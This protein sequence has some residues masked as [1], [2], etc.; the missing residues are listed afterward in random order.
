MGITIN[1][2]ILALVFVSIVL[3]VEGVFYFLRGSDAREL[4]ANRRM[5]VA[6]KQDRSVLNPSLMREEVLGGIT[7]R[8]I[9][10]LMPAIE[11]LFWVANIAIKPIYAVVGS[12]L[13]AIAI[14]FAFQTFLSMPVL[15]ALG[16]G[17]ML[18]LG[19]PYLILKSMAD[20]QRKKFSE[21]LPNAINLISRGLQAG[22]PVPVTFELV[23]RELEDPIGGQFGKVI[24]EINFGRDRDV[25]LR[26]VGKKFP[27][28]DFK[29][30]L[31]AIEMQRE[32][33]GNLVEILDNLSKIIRERSNMRKKAWAISSEGRMTLM[34]VGSLPYLLLAYFL[35]TNPPF[36]LDAVDHELFWPLMG[37]AQ[38][39]WV[40]GVIWIWKMVNIKV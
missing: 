34:I 19:I 11:E 7:S 21:Q 6:S 23:A 2:I 24:D 9:F 3:A 40:V 35:M 10:K 18:G 26:D 31:A 36:I 4:A 38:A 39:L 5:K 15:V 27:D 16:F 33:G 37:G 20:G 17:A 14:F 1:Q 8:A 32:T 12:I 25:A 30:F 22:H 29:F 28:P 13:L